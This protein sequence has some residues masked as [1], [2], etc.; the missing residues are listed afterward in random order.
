M[1]SI[2][3]NFTSRTEA[4]IVVVRS[5]RIETSMDAGRLALS[6]GNSFFTRSTTWM[7]FAPGCRW[8][9]TMT[10]GVAF[11]HAASLVFSTSSITFATSDKTTGAPLRYATTS[12]W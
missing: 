6:C 7:M 3:E 8:M 5:V 2:S 11:A 9:F 12:D 4:R 10:A 1:V